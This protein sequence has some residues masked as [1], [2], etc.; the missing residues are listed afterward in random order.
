LRSACAGLQLL[1][2][3]KCEKLTK[4]L[5]VCER[6]SSG[7]GGR[8]QVSSSRTCSSFLMGVICCLT[9]STVCACVCVCER[10]RERESICLSVSA[11][12]LARARTRASS[13]ALIHALG[14][15]RAGQMYSSTFN[16]SPNPYPMSRQSIS[17]P[18]RQSLVA[19]SPGHTC[20]H[21]CMRACVSDVVLGRTGSAGLT[22]DGP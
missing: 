1:C 9:A 22:G 13:V 16:K 4:M 17:L 21:A 5:C 2:H 20:V 11:V 12:A 19:V 6:P 18:G 3:N 10:E 15:L 7:G 14:C 8:R